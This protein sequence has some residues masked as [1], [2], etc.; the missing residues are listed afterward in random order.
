MTSAL[1]SLLYLRGSKVDL[2]VEAS[3]PPTQTG[4]VGVVDR[5]SEKGTCF[6]TFYLP[7]VVL[8]LI[9]SFL[10]LFFFFS[11]ITFIYLIEKAQKHEL[12]S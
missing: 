12:N 7:W 1:S 3:I 4:L 2:D 5:Y 10:F 9:F 6:Q 8:L 11:I